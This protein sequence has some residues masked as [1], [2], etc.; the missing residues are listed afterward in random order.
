MN[1]LKISLA[2]LVATAVLSADAIDDKFQSLVGKSMFI[3]NSANLQGGLYKFG[4]E[5]GDKPELSDAGLSFPYYFGEEGDSWRPFVLGGIGYS[6]M[7]EDN[8]NLRGVA[9]DDI[10]LKSLYYKVG[11][12]VTYNPSC[13]FSFIVGGSALFMNTEGEYKSKVAL[14][15]SATDR[16]IKKLLDDDTTNI[17]YDGYGGFSYKPTIFGYK[18]EISSALHYIKM[19]FDKDVDDVDGIYL[20]MLAKVRS[21]ELTTL[22]CEPVWIEHY[23]GA[24][25]VDSKIADVVGFNSAITFGST[26]HWRVGRLIP[27]IRDSRFKDLNIAINAQKTISNSDME[28]W[29]A[30]VGFSLVKF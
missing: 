10:E 26:L 21:N 24:D 23:V 27:I 11:G 20:N 25:F 4:K 17:L 19:D 13:D 18:S 1:I 8:T 3:G 29:K 15:T 7:T 2:T 14:G 16:K 12:G 30:G 28:G 5:G 6:K 22:W 9:G